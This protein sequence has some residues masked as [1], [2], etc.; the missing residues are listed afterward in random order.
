[1]ID[2]LQKIC[3]PAFQKEMLFMVSGERIE[4]PQSSKGLIKEKTLRIEQSGD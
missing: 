2:F 1:M 4:I 3:Q